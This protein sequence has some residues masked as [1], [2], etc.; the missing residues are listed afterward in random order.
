MKGVI[1]KALTIIAKFN[2]RKCGF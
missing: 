2:V 1:N